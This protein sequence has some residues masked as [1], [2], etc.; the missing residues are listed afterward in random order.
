MGGSR[1][2][3]KEGAQLKPRGKFTIRENINQ[4]GK[5]VSYTIMGTKKD[6]T[7]PRPIVKTRE[8][9]KLEQERLEH[10]ANNK[11][12]LAPRRRYTKLTPVQVTD[13]EHAV[14]I[15][16][17]DESLSSLAERAAKRKPKLRLQPVS[18]LFDAYTK[19][20]K[21]DPDNPTL[22]PNTLAQV[23]T[24]AAQFIDTFGDISTGEL[25]DLDLQS[26]DAPDYI[27]R[28]FSPVLTWGTQQ[29]PPY[30]SNNPL[31]A[32]LKTMKPPRKGS[33]PEII[34]AEKT[35]QQLLDASCTMFKG[36]LF[37]PFS[38]MTWAAVRVQE[39][40]KQ[41]EDL[42]HFAERK[43]TIPIMIAKRW[44]TKRIDLMPNVH[45]MLT[46]WRKNPNN[47]FLN[48]YVNF[49]SRFDALK[50]A[51][52]FIGTRC[53]ECYK[54][55]DRSKMR[56][57]L[58]N[59]LR[60]TGLTYHSLM[61]GSFVITADWGRTSKRLLARCYCGESYDRLAVI[62]WL[63]LP[64]GTGKEDRTTVYK[65][66]IIILRGTRLNYALKR[67]LREKGV[68]EAICPD[69]YEAWDSAQIAGRLAEIIVAEESTKPPLTFPSPPQQ[70]QEWL[71]FHALSKDAVQERI[72]AQSA[73]KLAKELDVSDK[74][75]AKF[76]SLASR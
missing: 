70:S 15:K 11:E 69:D 12:D 24:A 30:L 74:A 56:R 61:T 20:V 45:F 55:K 5:V 43:I 25:L 38:E 53:P 7:R 40:A 49:E 13:A 27:L 50:E 44:D 58:R 63:M 2:E 46:T 3:A 59:V 8:E 32:V 23:K 76:C 21:K 67:Y 68:P 48:A 35:L 62:F 66:M 9:A 10:E 37:G 41:K 54:T 73:R 4:Y 75:L 14:Q 51:C 1:K 71:A 26:W 72:D 22:R 36:L 65:E 17:P 47:T 42:I 39:T 52:R 34:P 57:W 60:H 6:G 33:P 19:A 64:R 18:A 28:R 31:L 29:R 16:P